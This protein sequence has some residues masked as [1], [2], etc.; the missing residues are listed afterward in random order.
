MSNNICAVPGCGKSLSRKH[1]MCADHWAKVPKEEGE[2]LFVLREKV[3]QAV[4]AAQLTRPH[5]T[6]RVQRL[7]GLKSASNKF[8]AAKREACAKVTS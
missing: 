6:L 8:N 5:S 2:A 3:I 4:E 1:I 7:D